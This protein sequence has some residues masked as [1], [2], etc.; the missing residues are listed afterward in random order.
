M[1]VEKEYIFTYNVEFPEVKAIESAEMIAVDSYDEIVDVHIE[2]SNGIDK[3][4]YILAA[5]S[6]IITALMDVLWVKGISIE[7]AAKWGEKEAVDFVKEVARSKAGFTGDDIGAAIRKLEEKFGLVTDSNKD[8]FG[9]GLRHHLNDFSHHPSVVGLMFSILSQFT[10]KAFGTDQHGIFIIKDVVNKELIGKN[11]QDK[12]TKGTIIWVFH[13][14]SDLAGSSSSPGKGTGIPGPLLSLF[15]ELASLPIIRE[16]RI[17]YQ[18]ENRKDE[19]IDLATFISRIFSGTYLAKY[20]ENGK[21]IKGTPIRFDMRTEMG[22]LSQIGKQAIPV[23]ANECIVRGFY[24]VRRICNELKNVGSLAELKAINLQ[25]VM[26]LNNRVVARMMTVSTGTFMTVVTVKASVK[27]AITSKGR[28]GT[29]IKSFLLN[30][31]YPGA[32]RFVFALGT[33]ISYFTEDM[34]YAYRK[35]LEGKAKNEAIWIEKISAFDSLMLDEVQ[36]QILVSLQKDMVLHDINKTKSKNQKE[37]KN[38]WLNSW[39][40]QNKITL[41]DSNE[42]LFNIIKMELDKNAYDSWLYLIAME[43]ALYSPYY[44]LNLSKDD[45]KQFSKLTYKAEYIKDI[46]SINLPL[47]QYEKCIEIVNSLKDNI[48][49]IEN[50]TVFNKIIKGASI[51]A[52]GAATGG[53][54]YV[55]APGIAVLL[56]G[57]AVAGLSGAALTS[58]SLALIG[59]GSIAAGGLGMAGGTAIITGGGTLLGLIGSGAASSLSSIEVFAND[60]ISI[61]ECAKLL[62][63]CECVFIG[64]EH[65]YRI[66]DVIQGSFSK[67]IEELTKHISDNKRESKQDSNKEERKNQ[68]KHIE[69]CES[70][71]VHMERCYNR[72]DKL[73]KDYRKKYKM[74]ESDLY[75]LSETVS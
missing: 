40:E 33:E 32:V 61:K 53:M 55:F 18:K 65:N 39:V 37:L 4:D 2:E 3:F 68:K 30:I 41:I 43:L 60:D 59:G 71:L 62:S 47:K 63:F 21:M 57:E 10:E 24:F 17:N 19:E 23:L 36:T 9:G 1:M 51:I 46:F 52:V 13:L 48:K 45:D 67:S 74:I 35:K 69:N 58:A 73:L 22:V 31:N 54:A 8:D 34:I 14:I 5:S 20:D 7:D 72:L 25:T 42:E 29:F 56:A 12:L 66:V 50:N 27:A 11:V 49:V 28:K 75:S 26:P 38:R 70:V 16:I 15:K 6:G 64:S 44:P